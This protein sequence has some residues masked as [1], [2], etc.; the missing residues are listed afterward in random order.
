MN[1]VLMVMLLSSA[2]VGAT[3]ANDFNIEEPTRGS[4]PWGMDDERG[5]INR[6]TPAKIIEAAQL[7]EEGIYYSLGREYDAEMPFVSGR[8][9]SMIIP[10]AAPPAGKNKIVGYEEF[11]S[12]QLGQV[13]TQL[14]GL[15]HVGIGD[16]FFN[17]FDRNEFV[18]PNGLKKLGVENIGVFLTRGLLLDIAALKGKERLEI[19]Y[20]ITAQDLKDTLKKQALEIHPG[21]VILIHTGWGNLWK[22]DNELHGS[23]EPGIDLSA[24]HFLVDQ[25]ITLFGAD[26]WA[27]EVRPGPDPDV[28][29]PVHQVLLTQNGIYTLENLDTSGLARDKVYEFA[30]FFA[31]LK[32]KGGTGSPGNPVAIH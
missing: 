8:H 3:S 2:S 26:N 23:G 7:I 27:I 21:D 22:V 14:D 12:T 16:K 10:S 18:T 19:G 30:F 32:L 13:G 11:I 20:P 15:G 5:A 31:P 28:L 1:N 25:Q 17:G 6:I 29:F 24:A 4:S 9:Y